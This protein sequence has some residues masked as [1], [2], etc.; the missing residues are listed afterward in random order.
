MT[1]PPRPPSPPSGPPIGANF[2]RRNELAPEPPVPASTLIT[3]RST[4]IASPVPDACPEEPV[5]RGGVAGHH[6]R[7]HVQRALDLG[8]ARARVYGAVQVRVQLPVLSLH[9][10]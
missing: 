6:R 7:R 3:T 2:S 4:N 5:A 10:A 1:S 9:G 8:V